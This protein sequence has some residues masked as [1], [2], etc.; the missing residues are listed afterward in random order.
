[1]ACDAIE[2]GMSI[3]TVAK[4]GGWK[5]PKVLLQTYTKLTNERARKLA[6]QHLEKKNAT[7][8]EPQQTPTR[9]ENERLM[10]LLEKGLIDKDTFSRLYKSSQPKNTEN[11][12]YT[13]DPNYQ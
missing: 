3:N 6:A 9:S 8:P 7:T 10:D 11:T 1:M 2:S 13:N 5:D 12:R 4:I